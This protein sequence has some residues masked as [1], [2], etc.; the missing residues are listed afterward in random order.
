MPDAELLE[1]YPLYRRKE[2]PVAGRMV[3]L[4]KPRINMHCAKCKQTRTFQMTNEYWD[5]WHV[6]NTDTPGQRVLARYICVS[7][8]EFERTFTILLSDNRDWVMKIG[9]YPPWS[10]FGNEQLEA[11]LGNHGDYYK[12]GL[13]CESQGYGIA[14]FAY[15]RRITEEV[16]DKL[17]QQVETLIGPE[18]QPAYEAALAKVKKTRVAAEKIEIVKELL[19]SNL[20][21]GGIN[22]LSV[23]HGALSEGLHAESDETC[24]KHAQAVRETLLYLVSQISSAQIAGASF[25]ESIKK[26]L[27]KRAGKSDENEQGSEPAP[28][29]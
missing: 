29:I 23:L 20:R 16:I 18:E 13:I 7:C 3:F 11:L 17:L 19:P 5:Q 15:Y 9:Q 26:L 22:P 12:K 2:F 25:S 6:P 8:T 1:E 28:A 21:P 24:L 14:A 4:E 27:G 10:I